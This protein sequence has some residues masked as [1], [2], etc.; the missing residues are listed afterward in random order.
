MSYLLEQLGDERFQKLCQALLVSIY[1]DVQC[2]PVGQP[3]GGRDAQVRKK[4]KQGAESIIFQ[5][6][7]SKDPLAKSSREIVEQVIGSEKD[8]VERLI[9][10]GATSYHLMTNVAGTSHLDVGSIDRIN[11]ALSE[12][13]DITVHCWWRD[14]IER[15]IDSLPAIKWSFPEI[16]KA[17]DLL[18]ATCRVAK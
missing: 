6:K 2:F 11:L 1:P 5:V 18:G 3:D 9:E 14:D 12:A 15:R 8:K 7:Y 13:L 10:K 4:G 16:L 17:T